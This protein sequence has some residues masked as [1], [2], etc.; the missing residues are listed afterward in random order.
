AVTIVGANETRGTTAVILE[1]LQREECP[2]TG[3]IHM[4]NRKGGTVF[5]HPAVTSIDEIE[6]ELGI[7]WLLVGP[8][9]VFETLDAMASRPPRAVI[10]FS[11]GF[12]E[13]G[14]ADAQERLR[15]WSQE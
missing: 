9:G 6:G 2:F 4:V 8:S 7:V 12:A 10:V 3:R 13:A 1:S 14:A 5:G 11:G 15:R